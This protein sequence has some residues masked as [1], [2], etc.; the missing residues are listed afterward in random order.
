[1]HRCLVIKNTSEDPQP[2][3]IPPNPTQQNQKP[4]KLFWLQNGHLHNPIFSLA[5]VF[6][7]SFTTGLSTSG[8]REKLRVWQQF[9]FPHFVSSGMSL[10]SIQTERG[11]LA[12]C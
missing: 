6:A 12:V 4:A 3:K 10:P 9:P 7:V 5:G 8:Q 2:K 11:I 1:M